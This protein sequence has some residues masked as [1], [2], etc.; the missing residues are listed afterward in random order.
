MDSGKTKKKV[1]VQKM[2]NQATEINSG[3]TMTAKEK[4]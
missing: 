1:P 4:C 3:L 2:N